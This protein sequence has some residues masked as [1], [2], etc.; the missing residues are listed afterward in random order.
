VITNSNI[1]K[2]LRGSRALQPFIITH[3]F[4]QWSPKYTNL[5]T[6]PKLYTNSHCNVHKRILV[7]K[8]TPDSL[9]FALGM[10]IKQQTV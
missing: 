5:K 2:F 4:Q 8:M 10:P 3:A 7:V 9:I 6:V 1:Q